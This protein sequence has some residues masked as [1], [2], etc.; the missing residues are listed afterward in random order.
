M[1]DSSIC[2]SEEV[3]NKLFDVNNG[4]LNKY[5]NEIFKINNRFDNITTN[6]NLIIQGYYNEIEELR[7]SI[8]EYEVEDAEGNKKIISNRD[9]INKRI[10]DVYEYINVENTFY[11]NNKKKYYD[12]YNELNKNIRIN[13]DNIISLNNYLSIISSK[14]RAYN[15]ISVSN[16]KYENI[17]NNTDSNSIGSFNSKDNDLKTYYESV[18]E[19]KDRISSKAI[20]IDNLKKDY[21]DKLNTDKDVLLND[22]VYPSNY[23]SNKEYYIDKNDKDLLDYKNKFNKKMNNLISNMKNNR[24]SNEKVIKKSSIKG[25]SYSKL[26]NFYKGREDKIEIHHIP[27]HS[28]FAVEGI[29]GFNYISRKENNKYDFSICIAITKEDHKLTASYG[30]SNEAEIFRK[31]QDKLI[32]SGKFKEALINECNNI[33]NLFGHKY[34]EGLDQAIAYYQELVSNGIL[35]DETKFL[36]R[37]KNDK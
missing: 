16:N 12:I 20:S 2:N 9:D 10:N 26:A 23:D 17:I 33:R 32:R 1:D 30:S 7:N 21:D 35:D 11:N 24:I 28:I 37:D 6:H 15:S 14:I 3:V 34:D 27:P 8:F 18:D 5:E 13:T 31:K 36:A 25:G 4:I 19:N 29:K 22:D